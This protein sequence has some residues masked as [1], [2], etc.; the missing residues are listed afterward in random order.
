MVDPLDVRK[1][2][3]SRAHVYEFKLW[4]RLYEQIGEFAFQAAAEDKHN[5]PDDVCQ[6]LLDTLMPTIK[7]SDPHYWSHL[8]ITEEE[9]E[10][11]CREEVEEFDRLM[12]DTLVGAYEK[13]ATPDLEDV[14]TALVDAKGR[15]EPDWDYLEEWVDDEILENKQKR[16][17]FLDDLLDYV[18]LVKSDVVFSFSESPAIQEAL[19]RQPP[20]EK[21]SMLREIAYRLKPLKEELLG[22]LEDGIKK[23]AEDIDVSNQVDFMKEWAAVIKTDEA[24]SA[25]DAVVAF[26]EELRKRP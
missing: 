10:A 8:Q 21:E 5:W 9:M 16:R 22:L 15:L 24:Q 23:R 6:Q 7:V 1:A 11:I 13:A 20:D 12:F 3:D 17:A 4:D 26:V 18:D 25:R 2:L 19:R 14:E